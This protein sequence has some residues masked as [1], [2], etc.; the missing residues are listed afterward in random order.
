MGLQPR[1]HGR[2]QNDCKAYNRAT[3]DEIRRS[4]APL[5]F[6]VANW[7]AYQHK[8]EFVNG[9]LS[10]GLQASLGGLRGRKVYVVDRVPGGRDDVA[11]SL[12]RARLYGRSPDLAYRRSEVARAQQPM[13]SLLT[14]LRSKFA[15]NLFRTEN[16]L[17]SPDMCPV[18][19]RGEPLYSDAHHL[20]LA[21][22]RYLAPP[23]EETLSAAFV[24]RATVPLPRVAA[25][26][27]LTR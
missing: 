17:C 12:A 18:E 8:S 2:Q 23:I 5:I 9:S 16:Y 3:L 22:A 19:V 26:R 6:L 4:G 27:R 13:D 10:E 25:S 14:K 24:H 21:G 20:T 11:F 1:P 15:F 7:Y